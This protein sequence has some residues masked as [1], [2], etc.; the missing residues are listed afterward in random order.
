MYA[1][2]SYFEQNI[3]KHFIK[4][5]LY[6]ADSAAIFYLDSNTILEPQMRLMEAG[7]MKK[8]AP[9]IKAGYNKKDVKITTGVVL[10]HS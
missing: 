4:N 10:L 5:T 1:L 3:S 9:Q 6:E 7:K 8:D 2:K